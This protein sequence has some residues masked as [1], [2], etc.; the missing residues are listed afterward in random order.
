MKK[1]LWQ[2]LIKRGLASSRKEAE[3]LVMAGKVVVNE[4]R[5][6]KAGNSYSTEVE[7]RVKTKSKYVSRAGEKLETGIVHWGL[8]SWVED[9]NCLDV[10]SSTGGF[11][12]CLISYGAKKIWAV[13]VGTNQMDW[14]LRTHSKVNLFEK[15]DIRK[16]KRPHPE[17]LFNLVVCDI[18]F[19]SLTAVASSIASFF[20]EHTIGLLLVKPQ[21]ELPK[22]RVSE[23]GIVESPELQQEAIEKVKGAFLKFDIEM[24]EVVASSVQGRYGNQEYIALFRKKNT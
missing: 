10:G 7:L 1:P 4:Q 16:F 15:T 8:E 14:A 11:T 13:D 23:G 22:D 6:D 24:Q 18:S 17:V 5:A 21:F 12:D 20:S 19:I 9:S 3:A 2:L